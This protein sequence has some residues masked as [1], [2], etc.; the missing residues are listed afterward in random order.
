MKTLTKETHNRNNDVVAVAA[1]VTLCL[2]STF[3][4]FVGIKQHLFINNNNDNNDGNNNN[5]PTNWQ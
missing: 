5:Q 3:K 4:F 2:F 1:G